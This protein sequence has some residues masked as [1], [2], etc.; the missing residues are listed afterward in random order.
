MGLLKKKPN[1]AFWKAVSLASVLG[2]AVSAL[3]GKY[4][5]EI[6]YEAVVKPVIG[7]GKISVGARRAV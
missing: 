4:Y 1:F 5:E 3:S 6:C 7:S 2:Y